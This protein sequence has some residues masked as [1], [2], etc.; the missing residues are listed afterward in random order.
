LKCR[1]EV[2]GNVEEMKKSLL[3]EIRVLG[4]LEE[5]RSLVEEEIVRRAKEKTNLEN[6]A[7]IQLLSTSRISYQNSSL[8]PQIR[9][10]GVPL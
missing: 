4:C 6:V 7:L 3:E 1:N 5:E 10:L 8:A 2:F 9:W